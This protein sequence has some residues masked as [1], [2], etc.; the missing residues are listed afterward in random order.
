MLLVK[1]SHD[2]V[3]PKVILVLKEVFPKHKKSVKINIFFIQAVR[4]GE[5][6][7]SSCQRCP[8]VRDNVFDL[9]KCQGDCEVK[10]VRVNNQDV[11]FCDSRREDDSESMEASNKEGNFYVGCNSLNY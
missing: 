7:E 2:I 8:I 1:A 9:S 3:F 10:Q 11:K 4:C 6:R 5:R